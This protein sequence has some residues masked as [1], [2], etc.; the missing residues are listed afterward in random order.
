MASDKLHIHATLYGAPCPVEVWPRIV[1]IDARAGTVTFQFTCTE[2]AA[3]I[4]MA[5]AICM[6]E[7]RGADDGS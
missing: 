4:L 7:R 3:T 1:D 2:A 5:S 6:T